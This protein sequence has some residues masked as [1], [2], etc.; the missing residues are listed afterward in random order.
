VIAR[1]PDSQVQPAGYADP[2]HAQ[3]ELMQNPRVLWELAASGHQRCVAWRRLMEAS[4][5]A[6]DYALTPEHYIPRD[7]R[8]PLVKVSETLAAC[9]II[10]D[11]LLRPHRGQFS[12]I[13]GVVIA[14]QHLEFPMAFDLSKGECGQH[15][16]RQRLLSWMLGWR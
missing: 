9:R 16:V 10:L 1:H 6:L 4:K 7:G 2:S 15:R 5:V 13:R 8:E 12:V 3:T 14:P 11:T